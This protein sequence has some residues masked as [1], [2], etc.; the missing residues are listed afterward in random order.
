MS[1]TDTTPTFTLLPTLPGHFHF[2]DVHTTDV[3]ASKS[4]YA[5]LFGWSYQEI[6]GAPNRYVMADIDGRGKA[7]ITGLTDEQRAEGV[8]A[9]WLAY[10]WVEDINASY[11][12]VAEL[13]GTCLYEPVEVF[14]FGFMALVQDPTGAML[15]LWQDKRA[16]TTVKDEAGSPFWYELHTTDVDAA[17][18][19]YAG[20]VGWRTD[21]IDMGHDIAYHLIVP[22]QVDE[23]QRNAGGIMQQTSH[24]TEAGAPS[25]WYVY[26][27]VDDC[28]AAF[29]RAQELGAKPVMEPHDI[30]GAGR[31][32]WVADPQGA[33]MALMK[34]EPPEA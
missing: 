29:A 20:L 28:D 12:K 15:G 31:S 24:D 10:L 33:Y 16:D 5:D 4:F 26:F 6:P 17:I 11:A 30:P 22:E 8:P 25:Q 14:D 2:A 13:G 3:E 27:N 18:A 34:P 7:A 21:P 23:L 9:H 32:C 1:Q 19:F